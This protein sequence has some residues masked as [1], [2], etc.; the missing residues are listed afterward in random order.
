MFETAT[1]PDNRVEGRQQLDPRRPFIGRPL[2]GRPEVFDA[3]DKTSRKPVAFQQP[4]ERAKPR[5]V[6]KR[7]A[8][9]HRRHLAQ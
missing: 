9:N 5:G 1:V 8:T 7:I 4:G 6:R 2:A 3:I